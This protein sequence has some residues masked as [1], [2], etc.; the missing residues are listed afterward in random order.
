MT[1]FRYLAL[2]LVL[3]AGAT[4]WGILI[5]HCDYNYDEVLRAHSVWLTSQGLQPYHDFFECH[6]P[7]FALLTPFVR[8]QADSVASLMT[9]RLVAVAGNLL[10]LAGLAT[11][12]RINGVGGWP[13]AV[14]GTALVAFHPAILEYLGESRID[15]W[16]YAL[17]TWSI[18][19]LLRSQRT[20]RYA[21]LGVGTGIATLL[22]CPKLALLPPMIFLIEQIR[23]RSV[24]RIALRDFAMY[25]IG[26]AAA[27]GLFGCWL[28]ANGINL[29]LTFACVARYNSLYNFHS[30]FGRGLLHQI[31]AMPTLSLPVLAALLTWAVH[32]FRAK[33]LPAAYPLALALWLLTQ[34][35]MVSYP[36]KQYYG[37]WFLFASGFFPFLYSTLESLARRT[38]FAV[39][40]GLCGLSISLSAV[41]AHN[42]VQSHQLKNEE[43]FLRT[44]NE[45]TNPEDYIVTV[46]PLHPIDRRDTFYL[47][48]NTYDPAGHETEETL[49]EIPLL[50]HHV[51][52]QRYREELKAH[53][54]VLVILWPDSYPRRQKAVL[55]QFLQENGYV[56]AMLEAVPVAV[57]PDRLDRFSSRHAE[58]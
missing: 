23:R 39:F 35:L 31:M 18:V 45:I 15:G 24:L 17:A 5:T 36:Y 58:K 38:M 14:L 10:F 22:F 16:G 57:R 40:F 1:R 6:P 28:A 41:S 26:A 29:N 27:G 3:I 47:F 32:C 7:Y 33:T 8:D 56:K 49:D 19:W 46:P 4:A 52:E 9:L 42:W 2:A 20:W 44:L 53:P 55:G 25:A 51:S 48:F 13:V 43:G 21:A 12:A 34:A 50:R 54:P 30:G 11:L 37:P